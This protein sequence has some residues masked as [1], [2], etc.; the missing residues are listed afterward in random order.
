MSGTEP[1]SLAPII[2]TATL[3]SADFA[4]LN[5]LRQRHFPPERNL[6]AAHLTLF[7]A[8][9]PSVLPELSRRLRAISSGTAPAARASG[10]LN[11]G[12]GVAIRIGSDGLNAIR[13]D[14]AEAFAG[15]LTPQDA[16]GFR[17]HV[18]IQNKVNPAD[19]RALLSELEAT[20]VPRAIVIRGLASFRYRGGPWE[21]IEEHRFRG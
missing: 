15:S 4:W 1:V 11:L 7:H 14:L 20:F 2:V 5:G 18:T 8:L 13:R 6:L 19:A 16:N 21:L 10:L 9:P 12:R 3:G 17:A